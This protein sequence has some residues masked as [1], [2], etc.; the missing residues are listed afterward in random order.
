MR[1]LSLVL[2]ALLAATLAEAGNSTLTYTAGQ[3]TAVQTT[4]IPKY[5][6][7]SCAKFNLPAT[8]TSAQLVSA[9]CTVKTVKTVIVDSCTIFTLDAAGEQAFHQETHNQKLADIFFQSS[10]IDSTDF[11]TTFKAMT[12]GQQN[13]VC[14]AMV[15][16]LT[17]GCT[18]CIQ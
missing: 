8:C 10:S 9:G 18:P 13:A 2:I 7:A 16:P 5:N 12:V 15:P 14:A 17:A 6:R 1:K 11:C 4:L 3:S